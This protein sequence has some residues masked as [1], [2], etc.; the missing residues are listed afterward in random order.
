MIVNGFYEGDFDHLAEG[1]LLSGEVAGIRVGVLPPLYPIAE[2][3]F[4]NALLR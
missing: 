3:R 1:V 2:F 4:Q